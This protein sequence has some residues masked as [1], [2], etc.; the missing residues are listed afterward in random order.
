[1]S[2]LRIEI[3]I[4]PPGGDM[5]LLGALLDELGELRAAVAQE[6]ASVIRMN[7][8]NGDGRTI[9]ASSHRV[10]GV[11]VTIHYREKE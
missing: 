6:M 9:L 1:M 8:K 4:T 5:G 11:V 10:A 3:E 7:M 2:S